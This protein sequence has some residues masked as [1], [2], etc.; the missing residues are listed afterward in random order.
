MLKQAMH[1]N[2]F[3]IHSPELQKLLRLIAHVKQYERNFEILH[4]AFQDRDLVTWRKALKEESRLMRLG[5]KLREAMG[6][7][8]SPHQAKVYCYGC[9]K[10]ISINSTPHTVND[11]PY[12]FLCSFK[13]PVKRIRSKQI[14][15]GR[16]L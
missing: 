16:I 1:Y 11:R 13:A 2:G 10:P 12:H 5:R 8:Q 4:K 9:K 6:K 15:I 7:I 3:N 14:E